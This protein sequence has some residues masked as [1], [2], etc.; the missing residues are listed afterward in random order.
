MF[1]TPEIIQKEASHFPPHTFS[2]YIFQSLSF[3]WNLSL[4]EQ[5]HAV[6]D[7]NGPSAAANLQVTLDTD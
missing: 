4:C 3:I 6:S 1:S 7:A 5:L 2:T